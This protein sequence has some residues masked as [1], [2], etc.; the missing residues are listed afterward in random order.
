MTSVLSGLWLWSNCTEIS[1][2]NEKNRVKSYLNNNVSL[3]IVRY[4]TRYTVNRPVAAEA[5]KSVTVDTRRGGERARPLSSY[6]G[7]PPKI[8]ENISAY[9]FAVWY[10]EQ[11]MYNSVFNLD[12]A[13]SVW[14]ENGLITS[15][16]QKWHGKSMLFDATFKWHWICRSSRRAYRFRGPCT[17][18][19]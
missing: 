15:G 1:E 8:F 3:M 19:T 17:R 13:R 14:S 12:F 7:P 9:I 10:S 16:R 11:K 4:S 5:L 2:K 6:G 18:P